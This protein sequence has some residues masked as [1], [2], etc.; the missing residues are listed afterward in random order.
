MTNPTEYLPKSY[1]TRVST[2]WWL[3][4]WAYLKFILREASSIFVAWAVV[5][6]LLQIGALA[7]GPADY[8]EL[9]NWL[10]SPLVLAINTVSL[11]FVIFHAVTWFNLAP[12]AMAVRVRGKRLPNVAIAGPNYIAWVAISSAIAWVLLRG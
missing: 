9:Q 10:Q 4:R 7:R 2:Y 5:V 11:L 1:H 12:K 8:A 6:T 3:T